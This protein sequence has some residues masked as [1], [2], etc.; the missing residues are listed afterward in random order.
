MIYKLQFNEEE[1]RLLSLAIG[2]LPTKYGA[3]LAANIEK[4]LQLQ[5]EQSKEILD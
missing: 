1:L 2:E 5:N 3:K 4:Q